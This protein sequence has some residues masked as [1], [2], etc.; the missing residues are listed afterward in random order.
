M[1]TTEPSDKVNFGKANGFGWSETRIAGARTIRP[2]RTSLLH[3]IPPDVCRSLM[4]PS[5]QKGAFWAS[6]LAGLEAYRA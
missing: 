3:R 5:W 1:R 2:M 4:S 6:A